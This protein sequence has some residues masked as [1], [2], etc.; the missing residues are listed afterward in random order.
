MIVRGIVVVKPFTHEPD[1]KV[2]IHSLVM[3]KRHETE[4]VQT[5]N[6]CHSHDEEAANEPG[7]I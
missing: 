5:E 2:S 1:E 4:I 6:C 7:A 3:M